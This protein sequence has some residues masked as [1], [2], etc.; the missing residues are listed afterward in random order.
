MATLNL[1]STDGSIRFDDNDNNVPIFIVIGDSYAGGSL[2]KQKG[3]DR[4]IDPDYRYSCRA[5]PFAGKKLNPATLSS[6]AGFNAFKVWDQSCFRLLAPTWSNATYSVGDRRSKGDAENQQYICIK[7]HASGNQAVTE[8]AAG[9]DWQSYWEQK[10][11]WSYGSPAAGQGRT[12]QGNFSNGICDSRD[13]LGKTGSVDG[14][15]AAGW[16]DSHAWTGGSTT[17]GSP[18]Q[19]QYVYDSYTPQNRAYEN[20]V[21]WTMQKYF[22]LN[23]VFKDAD[24]GAVAPRYI[25]LGV[26]GS[27]VS[28]PINAFA[29][30]SWSNE[31]G[32]PSVGQKVSAYQW[33]HD[34]YLKP[35]V[36]A[37][38]AEGKQPWIAGVIFM[39]CSTDCQN[40]YNET[41][42]AE[43][44]FTNPFLVNRDGDRIA[45]RMGATV[46]GIFEALEAT[47]G[48]TDV[49]CL[50]MEPVNVPS[51]NTGDTLKGSNRW[52]QRGVNSIRTQMKGKPYRS[53]FGVKPRSEEDRHIGTDDLHLTATGTARMG[54]EL[55]E[56]WYSSFVDKG[57]QIETP[58]TITE[59]C[60]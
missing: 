19:D 4:L 42:T 36:D 53:V 9:S 56:K 38:V 3:K 6:T 48:I 7:A 30:I 51:N 18:P 5:K 41:G 11:G 54:F 39:G 32:V 15:L 27:V 1:T 37:V 29:Y 57:L 31:H 17:L 25:H 14:H 10:S 47:M 40:G 52:Y 45:D 34:V 28:E 23:G 21:L 60:P 24:G 49:P 43:S 44:S 59:I 33:F 12:F 26:S 35:A 20:A 46:D 50:T 58:G 8:P 55:A 16:A 13:A 2:K 22:T